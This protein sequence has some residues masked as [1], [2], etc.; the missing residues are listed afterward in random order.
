MPREYESINNQ[1]AKF[2]EIFCKIDAHFL[3]SFDLR[4]QEAH[5]FLQMSVNSK[6]LDND[7]FA[8]PF[9]GYGNLSI[10]QQFRS[11]CSLKYFVLFTNLNNKHAN[12]KC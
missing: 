5:L 11:A 10:T 3:E 1:N 7:V 4:S 12:N 9:V 6:I 2:G 8:R